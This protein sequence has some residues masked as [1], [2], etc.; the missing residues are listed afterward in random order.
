M[1]SEASDSEYSYLSRG[2]QGTSLA[3]LTEVSEDVV[4]KTYDQT[5]EDMGDF[6]DLEDFDYIDKWNEEITEIP[7]MLFGDDLTSLGNLLD[8]FMPKKLEGL[9]PVEIHHLPASLY[10]KGQKREVKMH[11]N[12]FIGRKGRIKEFGSDLYY[13]TS[14]TDRKF[15]GTALRRM[16]KEVVYSSKAV[17]DRANR[18]NEEVSNKGSGLGFS[19]FT[20]MASCLCLARSGKG[21]LEPDEGADVLVNE[22]LIE[23]GGESWRG[24]RGKTHADWIIGKYLLLSASVPNFAT[25]MYCELSVKEDTQRIGAYWDSNFDT[26]ASPYSSVVRKIGTI[27]QDQTDKQR[28]SLENQWISWFSDYVKDK[29]DL[30]YKKPLP[31][32]KTQNLWDFIEATSKEGK[33]PS[34]FKVLCTFNPT[35]LTLMDN[36]ARRSLFVYVYDFTEHGSTFHVNDMTSDPTALLWTRIPSRP[37]R[38]FDS[39]VVH[40]AKM[41]YFLNYSSFQYAYLMSELYPKILGK[42]GCFYSIYSRVGISWSRKTRSSLVWDVCYY[43]F[44][45]PA[46]EAYVGKWEKIVKQTYSYYRSPTFKISRNDIHFASTLPYRFLNMHAAT[47]PLIPTGQIRSTE[48]KLSKVLMCWCDSTWRTSVIAGTSRFTTCCHMSQSGDLQ[49]L[50][51]KGLIHKH[52]LRFPD[53]LVVR[54]MITY[55]DEKEM[56]VNTETPLFRLPTS[57]MSLEK[58]LPQG[59]NWHVRKSDHDNACMDKII[60]NQKEELEN[61]DKRLRYLELQ[62]HYLEKGRRDGCNQDE[63]NKV[64]N[65]NPG[66]VTFNILMFTALSRLSAR[67]FDRIGRGTSSQKFALWPLMTDHHSVEINNNVKQSRVRELL[68]NL[69]KDTSTEHG[70]YE[71][72]TNQMK[73]E[74]GKVKQTFAMHMKDAKSSDRDISIMDIRMRPSQYFVESLVS[75]YNNSTD[76]DMM[77]DPQKYAKVVDMCMRSLQHN[78]S[79]ILSSEDRSNFCGFMHPELMGLGVYITGKELQS[80]GLIG[81]GSM[82]TANTMRDIIFPSGFTKLEKM[83]G[84]DYSMVL[85]QEGKEQRKVPKMTTYM[86]MMQGIY[87][88]TGGLINTTTVLGLNEAMKIVTENLV[89]TSCATTSD[90]VVRVIDF[91]KTIDVDSV[92]EVAVE[93]PNTL[94]GLSMMKENITKPIVST[95]LAEFNN[96]VITK[97]GMVPQAPI[98]SVLVLQPLLGATPMSDI[99]SVVNNARS[100]LFWG[101][102][103]DLAESAL[104]GGLEMFRQKWVVSTEKMDLLDQYSIIPSDMSELISGFFPRNPRIQNAM[105]MTLDKE[106]QDQVQEGTMSLTSAMHIFAEPEGKK[107]SK[108]QPIFGIPDSLHRFKRICKSIGQARRVANRLNPRYIQPASVVHRREAFRRTMELIEA[109]APEIDP[110]ILENISPP[111]VRVHV[112]RHRKRDQRPSRMGMSANVDLPNLSK[113]R[114]KKFCK[115]SVGNP[116]T[117]EENRISLL[118]PEEFELEEAKLERVSKI[119]GLSFKAPGGMPLCRMFDGRIFRV[120]MSFNF[121]ISLGLPQSYV[122]KPFMYKGVLVDK[123]LPCFWGDDSLDAVEGFPLAFGHGKINGVLCGFFK[124]RHK[125]VVALTID[126][127]AD[128]QVVKTRIGLEV[129]VFTGLDPTPIS[130]HQFR[131]K[132]LLDIYV[133]GVS[134]NLSAMLNLGNFVLSQQR[135][136]FSTYRQLFSE[137]RC[138]MPLFCQKFM[139]PYPTYL[140]PKTTIKTSNTIVLIGSLS[141]LNLELEVDNEKHGTTTI[142][143]CEEVP[144]VVEPKRRTR[145]HFAR[146]S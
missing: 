103:P 21:I 139:L 124:Q 15:V 110:K 91:R 108:S 99:V 80:T 51:E 105:W 95:N 127:V 138:E 87:A 58:D 22:I 129:A 94:L 107:H 13:C 144:V 82:L 71:L 42:V 93:I 126:D 44:D 112:E 31:A 56:V 57:L 88:N 7:D 16:K 43:M 18:Y 76:A 119:K 39:G 40:E 75:Y 48:E 115:V 113:I 83:A 134:G 128:P 14:D 145:S 65:T 101:D 143:L 84:I 74:S 20:H 70:I 106:I 104:Y 118:N 5:L 27:L 35:D 121:S 73:P 64:M 67:G 146:R 125:P 140:E 90:D 109:D 29:Q 33:V 36:I 111:K 34:P 23:V 26:G 92:R 135:G 102:P 136:G 62:L 69:V 132:E 49:A 4:P 81:A 130:I 137:R 114:A 37:N 9:Q 123:F 59:M 100:S 50:F 46:P 8:I 45:E 116:L 133:P 19:M 131:H 38:E 1:E 53:F 12:D 28:Q 141:I 61:R 24:K 122:D 96:I 63:F 32:L 97:D 17:W 89:L 78:G 11:Y 120:P 79:A 2:P 68:A 41:Q 117:E 25:S 142:D 47:I 60:D 52:P 10:P 98:H 3:E 72:L 6:F 86:H 55:I 85:R 54:L 30:Y 77:T 66:C